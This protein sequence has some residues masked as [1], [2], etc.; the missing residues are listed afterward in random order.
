MKKFFWAS[1]LYMM[2]SVF[3]V[4][5][6]SAEISNSVKTVYYKSDWEQVNGAWKLC[7]SKSDSGKEYYTLKDGLVRIVTV[8]SKSDSTE[9]A[10]AYYLFDNNGNLV[11]GRYKMKVGTKGYSYNTR[12][13][14]FY[15]D[16]E[17][18]TRLSGVSSKYAKTPYNSNLGQLQKKYWL[19][20]GT[21]F[22]Y[23]DKTG[24]FTSVTELKEQEIAAGTYVG[25]YKINGSYYALKSSGVPRTGTYQ[26]TEGNKKGEYFF[27]TTVTNGI[28][29]AMVRGSWVS[30]ESKTR[31][32]YYGKNGLR[33]NF[34]SMVTKL[35]SSMGSYKYLLDKN[36]YLVKNN[37]CKVNGVFYYGN[38]KGRIVTDSIITYNGKR[39][40][41]TSSG[42]RATY[43]NGWYRCGSKNRYYYFDSSAAG[44]RIKEKTGW[45]RIKNQWYYFNQ[46]GNHYV[47]YRTGSGRYFYE[48]GHMATGLCTINGTKYFFKAAGTSSVGN[49]G[50]PY[51]STIVKSGSNWYYA[52][53]SGKLVK[54]GWEKIDGNYYYIQNYK[55]Q[56][57]TFAKFNGVN[58]Y[59]NKD[60][61][62]KTGWVTFDSSQ[63][64]VKY[65][66]PTGNDFYKNTTVIING[67]QYRFDSNG[68]RVNDRS[69]EISGPYYV[70]VDTVNCVMTVYNSSKTIPVKS[71]RISPGAASTPTPTGTYY[72]NRLGRW[73]TLM[74]PSYGQYCTHVVG[75]GAGGII[76]HSVPTIAKSVYSFSPGSYNLLGQPA[77][78]GCIRCCVADSKWIY[79][80]CQGAT[81]R[82]FKG[83][84]Q[85]L[86]TLKG[87]LGRPALVPATGN[88]D[89][90]DPAVVG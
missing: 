52:N 14:Y 20:T 34:T 32:R 70:E 75:A 47:D 6:V 79:D 63:N 61:I 68:Y 31:W 74:G 2:L 18:A 81:I 85:S 1:L 37:P 23:Y 55:I 89:P 72:L 87:P 10:N 50:K 56:K 90:T 38:A 22:C 21:A 9:L 29:G 57:K 66:N 13:E 58:V 4:V 78:H 69:S 65:V 3:M 84:Y 42:K 76:I 53:A 80:R 60:G 17:H 33:T 8:K 71:M 35:D 24:K 5:G 86:E 51:T 77:S 88:Y 59:L 48:D 25:Y 19:W 39:Y 64:K 7:K 12:Y 83:T 62:Y 11:T 26:I 45:Q 49:G 41:F 43:R 73:W 28:K 46:N 44:G 16:E 15:M 54:S 36:G 40:Y 30:T 67:L 82:I 27:S